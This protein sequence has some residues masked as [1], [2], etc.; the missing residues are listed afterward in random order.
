MYSLCKIHVIFHKL[1]VTVFN[2]T[3][4][5]LFFVFLLFWAVYAFL[6]DEIIDLP[7][8]PQEMQ[9]YI[10]G[11]IPNLAQ[12]RQMPTNFNSTYCRVAA[13]KFFFFCDPHRRGLPYCLM[14]LF[15]YV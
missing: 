9:S 12:L 15:L 1:L 7:D 4:P 3:S 5:E 13:S 10:T 6:L 2:N 14:F 11:L 8:V